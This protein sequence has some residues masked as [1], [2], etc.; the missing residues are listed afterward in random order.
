M[1]K[2]KSYTKLKTEQKTNKLIHHQNESINFM[3][4]NNT[5]DHNNTFE[6]YGEEWENEV[7]LLLYITKNEK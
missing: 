2:F 6:N 3:D 4:D 5:F 1:E 7:K